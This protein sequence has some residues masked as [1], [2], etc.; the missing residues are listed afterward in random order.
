[1]V[2]R[3]R[4]DPETHT[5]LDT[6]WKRIFSIW[7]NGSCMDFTVYFTV[8]LLSFDLALILE[9][10]SFFFSHSELPVVIIILYYSIK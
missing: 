2:K 1:M 7:S 5:Q 8:N 6:Q 10:F 4:F 9:D 3:P